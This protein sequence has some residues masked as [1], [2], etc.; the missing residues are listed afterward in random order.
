MKE[1]CHKQISQKEKKSDGMTVLES[2][3]LE[4]SWGILM[5]FMFPGIFHANIKSQGQR[6]IWWELCPKCFFSRNFV[7]E[8]IKGNKKK[9]LK[10]V[11]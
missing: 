5:V 3:T 8:T 7:R 4:N 1:T 9:Q 6:H 2:G 11:N 10:Q